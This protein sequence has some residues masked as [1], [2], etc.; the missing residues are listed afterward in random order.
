MKLELKI[1]LIMV[2]TSLSLFNATTSLQNVYKGRKKKTIKYLACKSVDKS[3]KEKD[4]I[5]AKSSKHTY[6][7]SMIDM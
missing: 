6:S 1:V 7:S 5:F 2:S 3:Q 4:P